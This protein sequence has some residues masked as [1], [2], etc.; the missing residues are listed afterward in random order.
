MNELSNIELAET[1]T[2]VAAIALLARAGAA[3][4][5][6]DGKEPVLMVPY[7]YQ[8]VTLDDRQLPDHIRVRLEFT[9]IESFL[10]YWKAYSNEHS[11]VFC[12]KSESAICFTAVLDYHKGSDPAHCQ[13]IVKLTSA[14]SP[15]FKALRDLMKSSQSQSSMI[16]FI[17]RW[18]WIITSHSDADLVE[19]MSN[20][21]F[22]STMK[23]S[24]KIKRL[25]NSFQLVSEE[26]HEGASRVG[27]QVIELPQRFSVEL[28]IFEGCS[29][30]AFDVEL[31]YKV[32]RNS[33][34]GGVKIEAYVPRMVKIIRDEIENYRQELETSIDQQVLLGGIV[35][36]HSRD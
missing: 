27:S 29:P 1:K 32:E 26:Q 22:T 2:D 21:E 34:S 15:E 10:S 31:R 18:S 7:G 30:T 8:V 16:E 4:Y 25:T 19:I 12:E 28:P 13:H 9:E 35:L 24:N 14:F 23:F 6:A 33:E 3:L 36:L 5:K 11:K 17:C 20:L